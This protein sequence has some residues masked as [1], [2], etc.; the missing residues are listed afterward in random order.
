MHAEH[1]NVAGKPDSTYSMNMSWRDK[2]LKLYKNSGDDAT[3]GRPDQWVRY[4]I[5]LVVIPC[6]QYIA[7]SGG[8]GFPVV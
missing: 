8:I 7:I 4:V 1:R 3:A 6:L 5:H 2:R